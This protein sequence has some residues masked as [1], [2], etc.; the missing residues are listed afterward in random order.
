VSGSVLSEVGSGGVMSLSGGAGSL[1]GS[2][3]LEGGVG[4]MG[5][6]GYV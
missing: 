6:G 2:I 3:R 1:G 4:S 5:S